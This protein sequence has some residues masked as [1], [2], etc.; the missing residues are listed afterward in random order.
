MGST[1]DLRCAKSLGEDTPARGRT[2]FPRYP[3]RGHG[4]VK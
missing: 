2:M 3:I 1:P 4:M